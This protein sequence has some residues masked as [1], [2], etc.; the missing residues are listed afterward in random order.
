MFFLKID[1]IKNIKLFK[2]F[3]KKRSMI[4]KIFFG[5]IGENC[6]RIQLNNLGYLGKFL[7]N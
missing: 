7:S 5:K 4:F 6:F 3:N 2:L 1:V